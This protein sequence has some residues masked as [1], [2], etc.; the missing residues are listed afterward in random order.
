MCNSR[1][2]KLTAR[3]EPQGFAEFWAYWRPNMR[4]ND[5]RGEARDTFAKHLKQ[6]ASPQEMI[7]GARYYLANLKDSE[8]DYIPL[9]S[10]WLN[11][12]AY[13]DGAPLWQEL[14][15]KL[16]QSRQRADLEAQIEAERNR[17]IQAEHAEFRASGLLWNQF[18]KQQQQTAG[19]SH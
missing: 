4:R 12:R 5:G 18:K 11:R 14:Q 2:T 6:G 13:E 3:I 7:D 8:R 10:T 19:S 1:E 15:A 16:E 17:K 9:C